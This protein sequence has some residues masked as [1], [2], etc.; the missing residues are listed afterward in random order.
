VPLDLVGGEKRRGKKKEGGG[1]AD[2]LI[3]AKGCENFYR[4][5]LLWEKH[6]RKSRWK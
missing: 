4:I 6:G 1:Q 2:Q 5:S 3:W